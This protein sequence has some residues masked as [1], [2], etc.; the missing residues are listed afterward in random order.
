[1]VVEGVT[2]RKP[3]DNTIS[4][5]VIQGPSA[6]EFDGATVDQW[7]RDG[8]WTVNLSTEGIEP[9]TYTLEVDDGD[10]TDLV[11]FQ[12]VEQT[13]DE[14]QQAEGNETT[15]A[16]GNET[17]AAGEADEDA[18]NETGAAAGNQTQGAAQAGHTLEIRT[19]GAPLNYTISFAGNVQAVDQQV[20]ETDVVREDGTVTGQITGD[21]SDV[22]EFVGRVLDV[23]AEGDLSNATFVLDGEEVS[24]GE[25]TNATANNSAVAAPAIGSSA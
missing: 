8:I 23:S 7:G 4:V 22:Y 19:E 17:T 1:M 10:N 5:E 20:E 12:V 16:E 11:Q 14:Q 24:P 21:D 15:T 25:L 3:D 2:N 18:G 6:N 9:G 13:E